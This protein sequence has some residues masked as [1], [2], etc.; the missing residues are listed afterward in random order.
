M[1][2]H[3]PIASGNQ[4]YVTDA[5]TAASSIAQADG[6]AVAAWFYI[7]SAADVDPSAQVDIISAGGDE[8]VK[9]VRNTDGTFQW[10]MVDPTNADAYVSVGSSFAVPDDEWFGVALRVNHT[11]QEAYLWSESGGASTP[12]SATHDLAATGR[13]DNTTWRLGNTSVVSAVG[14]FYMQDFAFWDVAPSAA[15][16]QAMLANKQSALRALPTNLVW[17]VRLDQIS[18]VPTGGDAGLLDE[19]ASN[20]HVSPG[21]TGTGMFWVDSSPGLDADLRKGVDDFTIPST[22]E[23]VEVEWGDDG[24]SIGTLTANTDWTA[25]ALIKLNGSTSGYDRLHLDPDG[26]DSLAVD[27]GTGNVLGTY[28]LGGRIFADET[29]TYT[30]AE[31]LWQDDS[32]PDAFY[33]EGTTNATANITNSSALTAGNELTRFAPAPIVVS[34]TLHKRPVKVDTTPVNVFAMDEW[35]GIKAIRFKFF[36]GGTST[37]KS[38][39]FTPHGGSVSTANT[40]TMSAS[41][42]VQPFAYLGDDGYGEF[43]GGELGGLSSESDGTEIDWTWEVQDYDDNWITAD[44]DGTA[45]PTL[46]IL[47]HADP[48][49]IHLS[50]TGNDTTG[51]GSSGNP[52]ATTAA[53]ALVTAVRATTKPVELIHAAGTYP[54]T[55]MN[56]RPG[57]TGTAHEHLI[58]LRPA[59]GLDE[60]D[61]TYSNAGLGANVARRGNF[62]YYRITRDQTNTIYQWN[63]GGG[64]P[65]EDEERV[66]TVL[67]PLNGRKDMAAGNTQQ[68]D[69]TDGDY[70]YAIGC[71]ITGTYRG[72]AW[73]Y[74]NDGVE[75]RGVLDAICWN[76]EL[77]DSGTFMQAGYR[78]L[79]AGRNY[80]HDNADG[81]DA[82][83][84][85]DPHFDCFHWYSLDAANVSR[86]GVACYNRIENN[87]DNGTAYN[88]LLHNNTVVGL[89]CAF[90]YRNDIGNQPGYQIEAETT[91]CQIVFCVDEASCIFIRDEGA[92][93][94]EGGRKILVQNS[95][96]NT[97]GELRSK[98]TLAPEVVLGGNVTDDDGAYGSVVES[99]GSIVLTSNDPEDWGLTDYA[100]LDFTPAEGGNA[101]TVTTR[102]TN[103]RFDINGTAMNRAAPLAAGAFQPVEEDPIPGVFNPN[104]RF[105]S[106]GTS[107]GFFGKIFNG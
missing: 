28:S 90:N 82:A 98:L 23:T 40:H 3:F 65:G 33:S 62:E 59:D 80:I 96:L 63:D 55:E 88:T 41:A 102:P 69:G 107:L 13:A 105:F 68:T 49:Q 79:L 26:P 85:V 64:S 47:K 17:N 95:L 6:F 52:Y 67:S 14:D 22:G 35:H 93:E 76:N 24:E 46:T 15:N 11:D 34:A 81:V 100:G 30:I 1:S 36:E 84:P 92:A 29:L 53:A 43:W 91:N 106:P 16:L 58:M 20:F 78:G 74:F 51:D 101:L 54:Y 56:F 37:P 61:V 12:A 8:R 71:V 57:G 27:G 4:N 44:A 99:D 48:L 86:R 42:W 2:I 9:L 45:F 104:S 70:V 97:I 77:T 5:N 38:V 7:N 19:T 89:G 32:T 94:N 75:D 83:W 73:N 25:R 31:R 60:T 50:P 39:A 21:G 103:F 87:A 72:F 10:Y 66:C 18:G